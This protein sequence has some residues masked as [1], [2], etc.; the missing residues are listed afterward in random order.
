[1]DKGYYK[2]VGL[3]LTA[4]GG[5]FQRRSGQDTD[6]AASLYQ[7]PPG[8]DPSWL[9]PYQVYIIIIIIIIITVFIIAIV[10]LLCEQSVAPM[11][12]TM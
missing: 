11:A 1:M 3:L 12:N 7:Y 9:M 10:N 5:F 6:I 4:Q 2:I 8:T